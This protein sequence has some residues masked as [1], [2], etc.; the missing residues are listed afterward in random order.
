MYKYHLSYTI[1]EIF[2]IN[3]CKT[4]KW[5]GGVEGK[6]VVKWFK[7]MTWMS[8]HTGEVEVPYLFGKAYAS[9]ITDNAKLVLPDGFSSSC[10]FSKNG[11]LLYG[12]KDLMIKYSVRENCTMFFNYIG[13]STFYVTIYNEAGMGI[14]NDLPEK[15]SLHTAKLKMGP[16]MIILSDSDDG[17]QTLKNVNLL[18][19]FWPVLTGCW[20]VNLCRVH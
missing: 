19:F 4:C 8:V 9:A 15:L 3:F 17:N 7:M 5:I 18:D 16:D 13:N 20:F 2:T 11:D 14:F 12:L 10:Y 1:K 6:G